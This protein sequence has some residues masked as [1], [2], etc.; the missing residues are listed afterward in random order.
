MSERL[1]EA[2]LPLLWYQITCKLSE[3]RSTISESTSQSNSSKSSSS[4]D[5]HAGDGDDYD[6]LTRVL[7]AST[8][9]TLTDIVL[10]LRDT[11][12]TCIF[13]CEGHQIKEKY[14]MFQLEWHKHCSA[15]LLEKSLPMD[16]IGLPESENKILAE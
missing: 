10:H 5:S 15:F 7:S 6:K 13:K 8:A 2:D 11:F 4:H 16:I 12:C 14:C 1:R 9:S 3:S